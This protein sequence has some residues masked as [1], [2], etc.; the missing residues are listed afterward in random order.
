MDETGLL[1]RQVILKCFILGERRS[2]GR[3]RLVF[4]VVMPKNISKVL[5]RHFKSTN[6]SIADGQLVVQDLPGSSIL[7]RVVWESWQAD[8]P[9]V[10][11]TALTIPASVSKG[12]V[13]ERRGGLCRV[14]GVKTS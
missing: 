2:I 3:Y 10:D 7:V 8:Y 11:S 12:A 13:R 6:D 4:H 14:D 9:C 1:V 5:Y